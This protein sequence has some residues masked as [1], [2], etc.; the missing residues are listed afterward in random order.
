[1]SST[2]SQEIAELEKL[3]E[4]LYNAN[5]PQQI[6]EANKL[7]ENFANSTDCLNKCKILLDRGISPYSQFISCRVLVKAISRNTVIL[8]PQDKYDLSI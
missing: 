2:T 6:H 4:Q 7:L 5:S 3:C 1:M 8:S